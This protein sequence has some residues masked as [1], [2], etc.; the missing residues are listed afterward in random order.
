MHYYI[1]LKKLNIREKGIYFYKIIGKLFLNF[2]N[3]FCLNKLFKNVRQEILVLRKKL[4][5]WNECVLQFFYSHN[6]WHT[7]NKQLQIE[8]IF[9]PYKKMCGEKNCSIHGLYI[10]FFTESNDV[11]IQIVLEIKIFFTIMCSWILENFWA[12]KTCFEKS[13]THTDLW[14]HPSSLSS[15][16][17]E[18]SAKSKC[19]LSRIAQA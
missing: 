12:N 17:F 19:G 4:Y 10:I 1:N 9:I 3:N 14:K 13:G 18:D 11:S 6:C 15:N 16:Y 5:T 7:I 8:F 2:L